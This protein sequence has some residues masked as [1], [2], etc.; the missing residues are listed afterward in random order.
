MAQHFRIAGGNVFFAED[1]GTE[2]VVDVVV[3]VG[4]FV[5]NADHLSLH[6]GGMAGSPVVQDP[7]PDLFRQVQA[8]SVFFEKF[9]CADALL[10]MAEPFGPD[11]VQDPLPGMA[12]GCVAQV[13]AEG[14]SF[15]EI[16]VETQ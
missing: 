10:R 9:H 4:D 14:D 1:A 2:R 12:E 11:T 16:F 8:A 15:R 6:G 7:V 3:D 13:M 5:G